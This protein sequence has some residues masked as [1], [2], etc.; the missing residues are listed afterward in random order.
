M[1]WRF[2]GRNIA[3]RC[4][5]SFAEAEIQ[6]NFSFFF[7]RRRQRRWQRWAFCRWRTIL[8]VND[9]WKPG[10]GQEGRNY[11]VKWKLSAK[12][13]GGEGGGGGG[14][15]RPIRIVLLIL[16]LLSGQV[17]DSIS[18]LHL[19][20]NLTGP[21]PTDWMSGRQTQVQARVQMYNRLLYGNLPKSR[22]QLKWGEV[23]VKDMQITESIAD[24]DS[25]YG[26]HFLAWWWLDYI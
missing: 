4:I 22:E 11:N 26:W 23:W 24:S 19:N 17:E 20:H 16:L 1:W 13:W 7:G 14:E 12:R 2:A 5:Y 8:A 9:S 18:S 21:L 15:V 3:G 10:S 6:L 25:H